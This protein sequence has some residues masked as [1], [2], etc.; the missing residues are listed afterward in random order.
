MAS[1]GE[2][3]KSRGGSGCAGWLIRTAIVASIRKAPCNDSCWDC[4]AGMNDA[5]TVNWSATARAEGDDNDF[6]VCNIG[7]FFIFRS[8]QYG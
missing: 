6:V 2:G 3:V 7:V 8:I 1:N 4:R 5:C